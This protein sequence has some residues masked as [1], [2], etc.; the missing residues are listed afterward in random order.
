MWRASPSLTATTG[1]K[2]GGEGGAGLWYRIKQADRAVQLRVCQCGVKEGRSRK[3][4]GGGRGSTACPS[5]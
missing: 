5:Q 3:G 4:G 2:D 1:T